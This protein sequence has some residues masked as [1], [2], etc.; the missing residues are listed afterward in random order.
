MVKANCARA[1]T[2]ASQPSNIGTIQYRYK[3]DNVIPKGECRLSGSPGIVD[4]YHA[5]CNDGTAPLANLVQLFALSSLATVRSISSYWPSPACSNTT[6]PLWST[7][8]C[9]GQYW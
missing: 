8:Y 1:S 6:L 9:A 3:A 4:F 5:G 7:I 2:T